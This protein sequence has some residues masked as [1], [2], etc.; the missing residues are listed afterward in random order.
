MGVGVGQATGG[1]GGVVGRNSG[2][3]RQSKET[4][5]EWYVLGMVLS[6]SVTLCIDVRCGGRGEESGKRDRKSRFAFVPRKHLL[7]SIKLSGRLRR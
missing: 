7:A 3:D 4:Y 6:C 1:W 5:W 2:T